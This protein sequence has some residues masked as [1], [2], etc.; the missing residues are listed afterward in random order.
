[1]RRNKGTLKMQLECNWS[2]RRKGDIRGSA[3]FTVIISESFPNHSKLQIQEVQQNPQETIAK[4]RKQMKTKHI[5]YTLVKL[6]KNKAKWNLQRNHEAGGGQY[7]L[8]AKIK[9][10]NAEF[11]QKQ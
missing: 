10:I 7:I 1:M 5:K 8:R 3:I 11:H 4:K 9:R 6:L 2:T